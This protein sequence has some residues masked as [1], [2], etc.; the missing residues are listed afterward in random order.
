VFAV[1]G[2][3]GVGGQVLEEY[4]PSAVSEGP[5]GLFHEIWERDFRSGWGGGVCKT[6]VKLVGPS[7]RGRV[8]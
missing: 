5:V 7:C 4:V 2:R 6:R 3:G 8:R 1:R